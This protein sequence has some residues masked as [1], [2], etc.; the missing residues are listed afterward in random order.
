M[1]EREEKRGRMRAK[2]YIYLPLFAYIS[3]S[4]SHIYLFLGP[5]TRS[6][7]LAS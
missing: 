2:M 4:V 6:I 7:F 1:G 3:F 5:M